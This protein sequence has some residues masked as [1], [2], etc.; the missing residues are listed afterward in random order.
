MNYIINSTTG[1]NLLLLSNKT[2]VQTIL[3][4]QNWK[5]ITVIPS[6]NNQHVYMDEQSTSATEENRITTADI[7]TSTIF[8]P[9][10][11]S[12]FVFSSSNV[13]VLLLLLFILVRDRRLTTEIVLQ[14]STNQK[15]KLEEDYMIDDLLYR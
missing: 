3:D 8:I 11:N 1:D 7:F 13:M 14:S 5:K 9:K 6:D 15:K 2:H 10:S 4:D 12:Y